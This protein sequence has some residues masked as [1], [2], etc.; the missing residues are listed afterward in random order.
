MYRTIIFYIFFTLNLNLFA[1]TSNIEFVIQTKLA[2]NQPIPSEGRLFLLFHKE[3]SQNQFSGIPYPDL[4]MNPIFGIDL[5]DWSGRTRIINQKELYGFPIKAVSQI[6]IG[7]WYVSVL[8]HRDNPNPYFNTEGNFYGE[9]MELEIKA[10][11]QLQQFTFTLN[12]RISLTNNPTDRKHFKYITLKSELLSEFWGETVQLNCQVILP[13]RYYTDGTNQYPVLL[14]IGG[15]GGRYFDNIIKEK[16]LLEEDAPEMIVVVL[17]SKS[18][19]G[20]SYQVNSENNGPYG[21]AL[22]NELIPYV[23]KK[24]RGIGTGSSRFLTGTST[25]GWSSLALQIFYPDYF[26][27]VWSTCSDPVDFRQMELVNIYE[28]EN[29]FVNRHGLERPAMRDIN[30]EPRYTLR[31]EVWAEN[32]LGKGNSYVSGGG[33][34]GSWNAVF[35]PKDSLTGLPKPIFNPETGKID[36]DVAKAWKKY[37]LMFYLS[38]NWNNIGDKLQGKLNIWMGTADSY[39]LNNAMVL[40]DRFLKSTENPR[41]DAKINFICGEGHACDSEIPLELMMVQMMERLSFTKNK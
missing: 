27:G 40:F 23:E 8:Y 29:A 22:V 28:D 16:E 36:A 20:D 26:N 37:D 2:N 24:F 1:Q 34:W 9:P 5:K 4:K 33:Q 15:F 30:G 12:K 21:D 14:Y 38:K 11:D 17:D 41:S 13:K 3:K 31:T 18:P 6:P 32:V 35:S 19:F 39:Y 25:G 10:T 7:K